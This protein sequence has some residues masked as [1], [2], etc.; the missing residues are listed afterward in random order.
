MA[1][2]YRELCARA[3]ENNGGYSRG[4]HERFALS[5][6]VGVSARKSSFDELYP[7]ALER[8]KEDHGVTEPDWTAAALHNVKTDW[9]RKMEK[10]ELFYW[11]IEDMQRGVTEAD[12][13]KTL[14]P[15]IAARYGLPYS[16]FP[17]K[18]ARRNKEMAYYPA[19]VDGWILVDPYTVEQFD[20]SW[21]FHG[22]G[23]KHL[24]LTEFEGKPLNN[25]SE[26]LAESILQDDSGEY[27][28]QW[29]QKLVAFIHECDLCFTHENVEKEWEYQAAYRL[30]Q[31]LLE[32][33]EE[34]DENELGL[35]EL[36]DPTIVEGTVYV[37]AKIKG[38]E[39]VDEADETIFQL[40]IDPERMPERKALL[41][42]RIVKDAVEAHLAEHG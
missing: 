7:L 2:I 27:S 32:A 3:I 36:T 40:D 8:L 34:G 13:Y 37:S 22:R 23:G 24:C 17:K 39:D 5:W 38:V 9:D 4:Y 18:Y 41:L 31:E 11:I 10:G 20:V 12:S 1:N 30:A 16:R 6:N 25:C 35:E 42:A 21:E 19:K 15:E 28:N 14:R 29:C 33:H 26:D